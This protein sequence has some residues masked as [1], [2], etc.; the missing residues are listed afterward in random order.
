MSRRVARG[1]A[2]LSAASVGLF[3]L[4]WEAVCRSGLVSP[5]LLSPPSR[6]ARSSS[7]LLSSPAIQSDLLF[8][9]GTF[10]AS[11]SLAVVFGV[12]LG[13]AIGLSPSLYQLLSPFIFAL[14]SL[15]KIVLMPLIALW[16]GFGPA[17]NIFLG[18]MMAAFPICISTHTGVRCIERDFVL[19]ARSY[20]AGRA[21]L[22]KTIVLPGV[23]P[24]AL[25]GVRVGVNYAMVG[26]LIAEFF[27]GSRGI[28]YRMNHFMDNFEIDR[29]FVCMTLVVAFS[30]AITSAVHRI[31]RRVQAWRPEAFVA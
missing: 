20:R 31:E 4:G 7:E 30:L 14:N 3:L 17:S 28:G 24:F 1:G 27:A 19:L 13:L 12:T 18:A 26:V 10:L 6:I 29:F 23:T 11:L 25:S 22:L 16:L 15:P 8:T 5:V 2:W 21:T 9:L